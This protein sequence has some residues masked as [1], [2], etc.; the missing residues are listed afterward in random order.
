MFARPTEIKGTC[1]LIRTRFFYIIAAVV[2]VFAGLASP[3]HPR[4]L[5]AFI[6]EFAGDTLWALM[7]FLLVSTLLAGRPIVARAAISLAL[8]F[9]VEISQLYH[10]PWIDSIRQTTLG[11]LALGFGFVWTDLVCYSVGIAIGALAE[12]AI[13]RFG[14][15]ELQKVSRR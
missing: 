4:Q 13:T 15:S 3:R 12:L 7:L 5:P 9:L 6:A 8:A 14:G 11:G 1:R 10:A 2:V